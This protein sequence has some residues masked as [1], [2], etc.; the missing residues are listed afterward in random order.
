MALHCNQ[1]TVAPIVD[2][3]GA[4]H[5]RADMGFTGPW[6]FLCPLG[7]QLLLNMG[8]AAFEPQV[9]LGKVMF[10]M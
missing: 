4:L 8:A 9:R 10:V 1:A 2:L 3:P 7:C 5:T 6:L